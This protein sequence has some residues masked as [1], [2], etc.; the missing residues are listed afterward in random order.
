MLEDDNLDLS[1]LRAQ[2]L[3]GNEAHDFFQQELGRIVK[4]RALDVA[5]DCMERLKAVDPSN[6]G[7]IASIQLD[8]K[9][10]DN[11]LVW[12]QETIR[13]GESAIQQLQI[14]SD[15]EEG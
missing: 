13:D 1:I 12:L 8:L 14:M 15:E 10:A 7:K 3:L 11:A 2:I 9:S 6:T 5:M 4:A